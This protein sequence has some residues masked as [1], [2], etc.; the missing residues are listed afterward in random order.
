MKRYKIMCLKQDGES[1]QFMDRFCRF[2]WKTGANILTATELGVVCQELGG[3][4]R[5]QGTRPA[6]LPEL[7]L[8][9]DSPQKFEPMTSE[10]I[11]DSEF[12]GFDDLDEGAQSIL[13]DKWDLAIAESPALELAKFEAEVTPVQGSAVLPAEH[14]EGAAAHTKQQLEEAKE[15]AL[16][17]KKKLKAAK[18]EVRRLE[19]NEKYLEV[20]A[21]EAEKLAKKKAKTAAKRKATREKKKKTAAVKAKAKAASEKGAAKPEKKGGK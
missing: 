9:L 10:D 6:S 7:F 4:T 5:G 1:G 18:D 11:P 8:H 19:E 17:A 14:A 12:E 3:V 16:A 20:H 15:T 21:A 2:R 13:A